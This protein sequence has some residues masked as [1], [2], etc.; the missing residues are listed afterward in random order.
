MSVIGH[1]TSPAFRLSLCWGCLQYLSI[2]YLNTGHFP[3]IDVR[4][5]Q[6]YLKVGS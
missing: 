3:S 6:A 1:R 5:Q 4:F 2:T